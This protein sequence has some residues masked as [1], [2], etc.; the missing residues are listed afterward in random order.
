MIMLRGGLNQTI[1]VFTQ[2][3]SCRRAEQT[4]EPN[5]IKAVGLPLVA[6]RFL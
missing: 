2:K 3:I 1:K 5:R 4:G 6:S